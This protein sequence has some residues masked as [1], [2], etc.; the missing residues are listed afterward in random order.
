[1]AV[2]TAGLVAVF[3]EPAIVPALAFG[4]LAVLIQVVALAIVRPVLDQPLSKVLGR[5]AIGT[6]LRILGVVA[7]AVAVALDRA[8]FPPLPTAFAYLGVLLP[9][10]F[11]ETRFIR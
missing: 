1:M 3:G 7:F 5:R 2:V 11:M 6:G 8:H 10:L 9:L 4:A